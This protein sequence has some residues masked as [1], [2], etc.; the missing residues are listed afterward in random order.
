LHRAAETAAGKNIINLFERH[1]E[2]GAG[3]IK[4]RGIGTPHVFFGLFNQIFKIDFSGLFFFI[5][6]RFGRIGLSERRF[7]FGYPGFFDFR[8]R[9]DRIFR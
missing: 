6:G 2:H 3:N 8:Q 5:N 1:A 9:N 7:D 4:N